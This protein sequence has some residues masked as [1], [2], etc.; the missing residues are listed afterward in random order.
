MFCSSA[1]HGRKKKRDIF[2]AETTRESRSPI[3]PAQKKTGNSDRYPQCTVVVCTGEIGGLYREMTGGLG[4]RVTRSTLAPG[5]T[6]CSCQISECRRHRLCCYV[7]NWDGTVTP[8]SE[9]RSTGGG[10]GGGGC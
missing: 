10:G 2:D 4:M 7:E 3:Q 5:Q 9:E 8:R 1:Q 6:P